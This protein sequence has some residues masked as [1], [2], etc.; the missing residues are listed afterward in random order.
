MIKL[1]SL[2]L[3]VLL[4]LLLPGNYNFDVPKSGLV[5][6]YSFNDCDARD[7]TGNGSDGIL[8]GGV[9]CWCGIDEQGLLFDG[10]DDYLEFEGIVNR[11]FN[12]TDFSLS[13]YFK[14]EQYSVFK[15]SLISKRSDCTEDYM[16][17]IQLDQNSKEV[18]TDFHERE[19][20]DYPGISPPYE[21]TGWKHFALVRKGVFAYTYINGQ[22]IMK[23]ARCSGVDISNETPLSFSNSPCLGFTGTRR[24]KGVLDEMRVFD[25]ALSEEEIEELYSK[26]P[27]ENAAQDCFL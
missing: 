5:A 10:Y 16:L 13:F 12:T 8:Y 15:Q 18:F 27:I 23:G 14:P 1:S 21:G 19:D 4:F 17:D 11:Y 6:Y 26:Y 7:I 25:R 2:L 24:F 22:L 20:K 9:Q 3:P